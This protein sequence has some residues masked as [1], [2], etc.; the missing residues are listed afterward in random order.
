MYDNE[1]SYCKLKRLIDLTGIG[2]AF[3][4]KMDVGYSSK[5]EFHKTWEIILAIEGEVSVATDKDVF[6]LKKHCV[7]IHPPMEFHRH[8]NSSGQKNT[9][10]V[11][12]FEASCFPV[13][14]TSVFNITPYEV[15][16][17]ISIIQEINTIFLFDGI[18]VVAPKKPESASV[19]EII[20]R[21][22][23]LWNTVVSRK[24]IPR[25]NTSPDYSR[26]VE[27]LSSNTDLNLK[28]ADIAESLNMSQ[29]N[30]KRVFSMYSG[31]GIMTYFKQLKVQRAIELLKQGL[32]VQEVSEKLSYSSPSVFCNSFRRITGRAPSTFF[33]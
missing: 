32:S 22:E 18:H 27:F 6:T 29:S 17:F 28:L 5:G 21:S 25:N 12:T 10:A 2:T 4:K 15:Q 31:I 7:A 26:I 20:S 30:V 11:I 8:F 23:L 14:E 3:I 24:S 9:F 33:V 19:Q 1:T 16:E 13:S